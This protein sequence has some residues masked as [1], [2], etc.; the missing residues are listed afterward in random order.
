MDFIFEFSVSGNLLPEESS[1][2]A[3]VHSIGN[4]LHKRSG[5]FYYLC[6]IMK[7]LSELIFFHG[8][9]QQAVGKA[10]S[11]LPVMILLKLPKQRLIKKQKKNRHLINLN[12]SQPG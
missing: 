8:D 6:W 4:S 11:I 7:A 9:S 1:E 5:E 2:R 10:A 12:M 3:C